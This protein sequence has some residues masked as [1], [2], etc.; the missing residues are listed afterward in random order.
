MNL[1]QFPIKVYSFETITRAT[2]GSSLV[3]HIF[4]SCSQN[5]TIQL[6]KPSLLGVIFLEPEDTIFVHPPCLS[7]EKKDRRCE[8]AITSNYR[9]PLL[10]LLL[11]VRLRIFLAKC[12]ASP[13]DMIW[14]PTSLRAI[15]VK[16]GARARKLLI[17]QGEG[18]AFSLNDPLGLWRFSLRA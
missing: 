10:L 9:S 11:L 4:N 15:S 14:C 16:N 5:K 8:M 3:V 2:P 7:K 12:H 1:L 18:Q 13:R 17:T 6:L